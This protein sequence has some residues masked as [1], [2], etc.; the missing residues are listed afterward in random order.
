MLNVV[1]GFPNAAK[2][3]FLAPYEISPLTGTIGP[4]SFEF[5]SRMLQRARIVEKQMATVLLDGTAFPYS[6]LTDTLSSGERCSWCTGCI[7]ACYIC[8]TTHKVADP[9]LPRIALANLILLH[10]LFTV[11]L[12]PLRI[13]TC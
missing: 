6:V 10:N 2:F 9:L 1:L 13:L 7:L 11:M 4:L 3:A 12:H 8:C 5:S